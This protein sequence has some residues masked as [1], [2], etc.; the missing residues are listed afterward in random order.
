MLVFFMQIGALWNQLSE[1]DF[2]YSKCFAKFCLIG[3]CWWSLA[4][5][6]KEIIGA[7]SPSIFIFFIVAFLNTSKLLLIF[8]FLRGRIYNA[9]FML[10]CPKI[11]SL[12]AFFYFLDFFFLF[13]WC[14]MHVYKKK[15]H[16]WSMDSS[17]DMYFLNSV[18]FCQTICNSVFYGRG[19]TGNLDFCMITHRKLHSSLFQRARFSLRNC[20]LYRP[21]NHSYKEKA[22]CEWKSL[23]RKEFFGGGLRFCET[24]F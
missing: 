9:F 2:W 21:E 6:N 16:L 12:F 7:I 17:G 22:E 1:W 5:C 8:N 20:I 15:R 18:S 23:K 14:W 24:H 11:L 13:P 3:V 19:S 4:V 10:F